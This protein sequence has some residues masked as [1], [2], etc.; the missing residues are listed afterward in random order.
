M[1]SRHPGVYVN[2]SL[3]PLTQ[4]LVAPGQALAAFAGVH[5]R[6]PTSVQNVNSWSQFVSL[7][8]DFTQTPV[9]TYLAFSIFEFFNNGGSSA[10]VQRVVLANA[11]TSTISINDRQGTPAAILKVNAISPGVWGNGITVDV[12]DSPTTGLG[13]FLLNVYLGGTLVEAW[14]DI[15]LN[16]QDNRY[17]PGIINATSTAGSSYISIQ[18]LRSGS[19][20]WVVNNTPAVSTGVPLTTGSD[21]TGTID[22][23][24]NVTTAFDSW[25]E[26]QILNLNLPGINDQTTI[27]GLITWAQTKQTVFLV[28][29]VP[30][31]SST[32]SG[33]VTSYTNLI[34]GGSA[35]NPS[36]YIA[37]YGPWLSIDDPSVSA[38]GSTRIVPPGGAVLGQFSAVDAS[39]GVQKPPAGTLTALRGVLDLEMRF[40]GAN[41]DTLNDAGIN[42]IRPMPGYGF[43]IMGARTTKAGYPDRYVSVRRVLMYI[44]KTLLD[45]TRYAI[46]EPNDEELWAQLTAS[47]QG[48]L[49][50]LYQTGMFKGTTPDQ[51]F[52]VKCDAEN[53]P[54]ATVA[55]GQVTVQVGVA[56][57]SPAEFIVIN[58]GQ[59]DGGN[60]ATD[61][62]S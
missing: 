37:I 6:G 44:K 26:A 46:F 8:G 1:A 4:T 11:V 27:N 5:G 56:L 35:F 32:V 43:C 7:Y 28:V 29:D 18:D 40:T 60:T 2:E 12:V 14:P 36:S 59:F 23:V 38:T 48:F 33:T 52:F 13:R 57:Q 17:A 47:I 54:D 19:S 53:N 55:L 45:G 31:A 49:Q 50:S 42:I 61:N 34:S 15:S 22:Y 62:A 9:G 24:A 10:L 39:R 51:A 25:A 58:I 16:P 30:K 41:L 3:S 21:G 20:T